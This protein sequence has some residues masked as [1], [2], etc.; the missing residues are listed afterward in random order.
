MTVLSPN[1]AADYLGIH[2]AT[3][4]RRYQQNPAGFN[5]D[6]RGRYWF[7][8]AEPSDGLSAA[9]HALSK[10]HVDA[11]PRARPIAPTAPKARANAPRNAPA[12]KVSTLEKWML[13]PDCHVPY[14][15][16]DALGL[17]LRAAQ[18][19]GCT[20][21]AILGDFADFYAVSSHPKSPE[22]RAD[23]QSEIDAVNEA[24]D[25]LGRT[26]TGKKKYIAGNHE[27]R[28]ER[29]LTS[30][31]PAL[32]SSMRVEELFCLKQ[33]GWHYT[34]YK[35]HTTIGKLYLTHDAGKAG[36][37]AHIDAMNAFQSNVVIGHTHRLSYA[38]EGSAT[39]K[40]HVAAMLGWLGSVD[41]CEYMFKIRAHR[42]WAHGFG[43]AY[44]EPDGCVHV[45]PVPIV[46]GKVCVEGR[47]IS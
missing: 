27:N 21:A 38:V 9:F 29:Y 33:R 12:A 24:L 45:V 2:P 18:A 26:F 35:S 6:A 36:R 47:L 43:V 32:Y 30:Q 15:D 23:L 39:G 13:I 37:T 40:P 46:R 25:L 20:N 11:M 8:A 14:H 5:R 34:P 19:I 7:P 1:E 44:V 3:L 16:V 17:M 10:R 41:E 42:D 22:R 4:R 28:L 31:A